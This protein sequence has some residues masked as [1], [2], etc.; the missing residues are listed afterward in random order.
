ML[1]QVLAIET[2]VAELIQAHLHHRGQG[3]ITALPL[4]DLFSEH[5]VMATN[6]DNVVRLVYTLRA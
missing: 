1:R 5:A 2:S 6:F 3:H 4:F